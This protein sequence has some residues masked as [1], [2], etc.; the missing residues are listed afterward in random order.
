MYAAGIQSQNI[1][2]RADEIGNVFDFDVE[3]SSDIGNKIARP[4]RA[5]I[6]QFGRSRIKTHKRKTPSIGRTVTGT[7]KQTAAEFDR[8]S[9]GIVFTK[10]FNG[11]K[12]GPVSPHPDNAYGEYGWGYTDVLSISI[13]AKPLVKKLDCDQKRAFYSVRNSIGA[14]PNVPSF[15]DNICRGLQD[16]QFGIGVVIQSR[17]SESRSISNMNFAVMECGQTRTV[18]DKV[19]VSSERIG[20]DNNHF[21]VADYSHCCPKAISRECQQYD[22]GKEVSIHVGSVVD[23][24]RLPVTSALYPLKMIV[25]K[26]PYHSLTRCSVCSGQLG[27]CEG[28]LREAKGRV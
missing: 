2:R 8:C 13:M 1:Y 21:L 18:G 9:S 3:Y 20:S 5:S 10:E 11:Y 26:S 7:S 28:I 12:T 24:G 6:N 17:E 4:K 14:V 27:A 16:I 22:T 19:N 25:D 23:T 15:R